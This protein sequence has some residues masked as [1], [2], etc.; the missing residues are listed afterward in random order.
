MDLTAE[1]LREHSARQTQRLVLY[2]DARAERLTELVELTCGTPGRLS[3]LA[4]EILSWCAGSHP[5]RLLPYLPRL[6]PLLG[7]TAHHPAVRRSVARALQFVDVP[8]D[9]QAETFDRC[10]ELL[11]GTEP[12][13]I[14][15]YALT[16]L[17]SIARLHP[18]LATEV[19]QVTEQQ[20]PYALPSL[21]ARARKELPTLR[22]LA[23]TAS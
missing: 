21:R 10:L 11:G 9:L 22:Q 17:T 14:K 13:A 12:V 18:G 2:V 7:T 19:I 5:K 23:Q 20:L 15:V 1:L 16:V 8:E 3:Q 4:S 6:L